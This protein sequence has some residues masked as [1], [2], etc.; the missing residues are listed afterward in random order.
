MKSGLRISTRR[1][2]FRPFQKT[3][4]QT[5]I[6]IT[7]HGLAD[8]FWDKKYR[9]MGGAMIQMVVMTRESSSERFSSS[10]VVVTSRY[11]ATSIQTCSFLGA[12]NPQ[13]GLRLQVPPV[14]SGRKSV[15]VRKAG[16][17]LTWVLAWAL[18]MVELIEHWDVSL[19]F[20]S[21]SRR[22]PH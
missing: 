21:C 2:C 10:G 14:P 15:H 1:I 11:D 7:R 16:G 22:Q 4:K 19:V 18:P 13:R 20:S 6:F 3:P 12:D 5:N 17:R 9:G 8:A